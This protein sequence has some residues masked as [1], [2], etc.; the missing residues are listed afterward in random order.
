MREEYRITGRYKEIFKV[1]DGKEVSPDEVEDVLKTHESVTDAAVTS[2][3]G[4]RGDGYFEP[5]AYVVCNKTVDAQEL[6]NH[7]ARSLSAYKAPTGGVIFSDSIPRTGFGKIARRD[8]GQ[9]PQGSLEYLAPVVA[10]NG[11]YQLQT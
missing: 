10:I 6:A 8:L 4:R 7:V 9:V 11:S 1:F 2:R 3:P 5:V